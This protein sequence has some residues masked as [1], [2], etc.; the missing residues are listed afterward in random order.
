[1]TGPPGTSGRYLERGVE[2][3]SSP[4]SRDPA[5][6]RGLWEASEELTRP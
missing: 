3:P 1:M 5:R 6:A 2:A 4:D